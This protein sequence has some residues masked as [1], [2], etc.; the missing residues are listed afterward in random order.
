MAAL[1]HKQFWILFMRQIVHYV[2]RHCT[3]RVRLAAENLQPIIAD[4]PKARVQEC[5]P[6]AQVG[7]D[8]A[9]PIMMRELNLRKSRECKV[10]MAVF[11][12]LGVKAVHLELMS[13]LSTEAFLAAFDRFVSRR[14]LPSDVYSDC[15]TN[16][17][18]ASKQLRKLINHPDN[19]EF[20]SSARACS[21]HFNPPSAPHFGGL[22]EAAVRSAKSLLTR[23]VSTHR[24][25]L[26]EMCTV[27]CRV[28]AAL[29]SRPLVPMS[30]DL[31]DL[32]CLTPGHF[33]VGE[34]LLTVPEYDV[35][36]QSVNLRQR[37]MLLHQCF[38]FF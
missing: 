13:D 28:E 37:W 9:G 29:N 30:P 20:L 2:R 11:V 25:T 7:V 14:G 21:W 8:Y 31:Y 5:R 24:L 16:F 19:H 36:L 27:L 38:Q 32:Q 34:A 1:I 4:L 15:G 17:I 26:E 18:G 12:C 10:Y 3:V 22:W 35:Q 23:T 33:L 6:F